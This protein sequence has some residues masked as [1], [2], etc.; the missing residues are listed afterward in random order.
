MTILHS[1]LETRPIEALIHYARN[2]RTHSQEQVAQIAA[3]IDEFGMVGAIVVR[4]G[5]IAKGHG[6]LEAIRKIYAANKRLYP[7]PGRLQG[8]EPF[9]DG[10]APILDVSGWTDAQFRAYV[11]ADNKLALNAGWDEDLLALEIKELQGLDFN[12]DLLGFDVGDLDEL[13]ALG[14]ATPECQTD[15]DAVPDPPTKAITVPGDIWQLGRHRLLCGDASNDAGNFLA[16]IVPDLLYFDPPYDVEEAWT[17]TVDTPKAL[18]FT[19]HKHIREA[20]SLVLSYPVQYQFIWDT[21]I[22]WYTQNRP[23]CRHRSAFY[24]ANEHG[25]D[26]DAATYVDGKERESKVVPGGQAFSGDYHYR[27]LSGGRVRVTSLYRQSKTL[28]EAGNG[29]P[30][31]WVRALLSGARVNVVYEP[32]AGTGA[33]IIAAPDGCTVHAIEIDPAKVDAIVTRWE[34][35]TGMRASR[36]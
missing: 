15:P 11:I 33:T 21:V 36:E 7:P 4:D 16:G 10:T 26:S 1:H 30:V 27:P 2:S 9:P 34:R 31:A 18:V 24:C 25:W 12:L 23:L 3:S 20:M 19:D 6:T 8:A 28:D 29:K 17:W 22:S 5:V 35:F 13:L 14:D 32:F